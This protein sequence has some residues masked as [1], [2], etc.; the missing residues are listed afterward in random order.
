MKYASVRWPTTINASVTDAHA[1]CAM[2]HTLASSHVSGTDV[3]STSDM[4]LE[5]F[6]VCEKKKAAICVAQI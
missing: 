3:S 2:A 1:K 5:N 4:T 6:G